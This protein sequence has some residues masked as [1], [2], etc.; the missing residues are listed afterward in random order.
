[1][2]HC[3]VATTLVALV[4]QM[5]FVIEG[6]SMFER[7]E[8]YLRRGLGKTNGSAL[9]D[10]PR[11]SEFGRLLEIER[12]RA[13]RAESVFSLL[14]LTPSDKR[15][16]ERTYE[17]LA[18]I[19]PRRLRLTDHI[20]WLDNRRVGVI[21]PGT[22]AEGAWKAANDVCRQFPHGV[23]TP[24]CAVLSYPSAES[25]D[26]G[27]PHEAGRE[28]SPSGQLEPMETLFLIR[29]PLWKRALDIFGAG[30]GLIILSPLMLVVAAAIK[31][32]SPGPVFYTQLRSGQWGKPFRIYKFRSMVVDAD[33]Q[34]RQLLALN[35]QDGPA[36]KIKNDPRVTPLGRF[37]RSTSI[38]ELP[39]LWNVLRG[40]MTL[41][42]PR[43]VLSRS[44]TLQSVAET[45]ARRETGNHVHLAGPWSLGRRLRRLDED[46]S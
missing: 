1:M 8:A 10:F 36:F 22:E 15:T 43:D 18:A 19:L 16:E 12:H 6:P 9:R 30:V 23:P 21:F 4:H 41:V 42:G 27:A 2:R 5:T 24:N 7:M 39:Q 14:T 29:T 38:D 35:E 28:R 31:F 20:G 37:L 13:D 40:E 34:K 11:P 25:W 17:C 44:R 3:Q 26:V 32:T 33:R 45:P 46:G